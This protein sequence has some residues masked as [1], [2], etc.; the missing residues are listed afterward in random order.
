MASSSTLLSGS[1]R[2]RRTA[3]NR[4]LL[5]PLLLLLAACG[6]DAGEEPGDVEATSGVDHPGAG[7]LPDPP[8]DVP[9][10]PRTDDPDSA[11]F[12]RGAVPGAPQPDPARASTG[13]DTL[14]GVVATRGT[15]PLLQFILQL[16][17]GRVVPLGDSEGTT[18]PEAIPDHP[19]AELARLAEATV[20]V[21]GEAD[22][23]P[24]APARGFA[25]R[26]YELLEVEGAR[27][28][29]GRLVRGARAA[30]TP[31]RLE[32]DGAGQ[33]VLVGMPA[34]TPGTGARVWVLGEV[35]GDSLLVQSFGVLRPSR[36]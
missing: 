24:A 31:D 21:T 20:R 18:R 36:P 8:G 13:P 29:T 14:T 1:P 10:A 15:E 7:A 16:A 27:P 3:L 23:F 22:A 17:D 28:F 6:P 30:G 33:R 26:G 9:P 19:L 11:V 34:G 2:S 25:V 35:R 12:P 5:V 32:T 4:A